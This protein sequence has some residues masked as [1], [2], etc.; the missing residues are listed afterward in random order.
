[1]VLARGDRNGGAGQSDHRDRNAR[2]GRCPVAQ[3]TYKVVSPALHATAIDDR[4]CVVAPDGNEDGARGQ[5][6]DLD[7]YRGV[8]GRPIAQLAEAVDAPALHAS[9]GGQGAGVLPARRD[10]RYAAAESRYRHGAERDRGVAT[11][12]ERTVAPTLGSARLRHQAA[13]ERPA[14]GRDGGGV[15]SLQ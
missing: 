4:T 8:G 7:R 12:A 2:V 1:M 6:A 3:L 9:R 13:K 5:S 11:V 10:L 15:E 14:G